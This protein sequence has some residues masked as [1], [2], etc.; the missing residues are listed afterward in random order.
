MISHYLVIF[1]KS[2]HCELVSY[3]WN[4]SGN[5]MMI[6]IFVKVQENEQKFQTYKKCSF[7]TKC[8]GWFQ[9]TWIPFEKLLKVQS[10]SCDIAD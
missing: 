8:S 2:Y 9:S 3:I 6:E 7:V 5:I 4:F 10:D 1:C